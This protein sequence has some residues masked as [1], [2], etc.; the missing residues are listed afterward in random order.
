MF[1]LTAKI[2]SNDTYSFSHSSSP[3][4]VTKMKILRA[5][6]LS[7]FINAILSRSDAVADDEKDSPLVLNRSKYRARKWSSF[8]VIENYLYIDDGVIMYVDENQTINIDAKSTYS[9]DISS[10]WINA[11]VAVKQIDKAIDGR[12]VNSPNLWSALDPSSFYSYNGFFAPGDVPN[13]KLCKFTSDG[14]GGGQW[15]E[16]DQSHVSASSNFASLVRVLDAAAACGPDT[17]YAVG[18]YRDS[19]SENGLNETIPAAGI[20]SYNLTNRQWYND[21]L[22]E[23]MFKGPWQ[24]DQLF[25]T[26]VAGSEGVLIAI[27]GNVTNLAGENSYVLSFG[28]VYIYDIANKS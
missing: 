8:I 28:D 2:E 26:N 19:S 6:L 1:G 20:V 21:S 11:T 18:G 14:S 22:V 15:F 13:N 12:N 17:C 9:I 27:G 5:I 16:D 7:V 10:S 3:A 24:G 25:F 23:S 4:N